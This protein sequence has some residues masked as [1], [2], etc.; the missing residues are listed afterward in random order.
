MSFHLNYFCFL[1]LLSLPWFIYSQTLSKG[2]YK[3]WIEGNKIFY[4]VLGKYSCRD[5][6][7]R[8]FQLYRDPYHLPLKTANSLW[9]RI[10]IFYQRN[11]PDKK[12]SQLHSGKSDRS[13]AKLDSSEKMYHII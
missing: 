13:T 1:L 4:D 9:I 11:L 2:S 6:E 3:I 7:D 10:L 8:E 5:I 12:I